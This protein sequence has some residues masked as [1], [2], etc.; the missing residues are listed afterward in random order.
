L[1]SFSPHADLETFLE[2]TVLTLVAVMLVD[3]TV[4]TAATCVRQVAANGP[5]EETLASFARELSVMFPRT[6]VAADDTFD[7][8]L[9]TAISA[10]TSIC[11]A[12]T[13]RSLV[14]MVLA[15]A[16]HVVVCRAVPARRCASATVAADP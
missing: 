8:R 13:R 5:L 10:A 3:R 15:A 12:T 1:D 2:P 6:L 14:M 4:A 7:T 11:S 9:F 16:G